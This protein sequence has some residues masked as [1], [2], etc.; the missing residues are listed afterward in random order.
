MKL[1]KTR[2]SHGLESS[3]VN[4]PPKS[5]FRYKREG[6]EKTGANWSFRYTHGSLKA[7]WELQVVKVESVCLLSSHYMLR[8]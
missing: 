2:A 6:S 1:Y 4:F 3:F 8:I 7:K 5:C